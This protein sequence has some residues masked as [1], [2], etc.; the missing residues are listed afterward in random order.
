MKSARALVWG[1]V[2][3]ETI[4]DEDGRL[5][6]QTA[7]SEDIETLVEQATTFIMQYM[8]RFEME[9]DEIRHVL[10]QDEF[11]LGYVQGACAAVAGPASDTGLTGFTTRVCGELLGGGMNNKIAVFERLRALAEDD[12]FLK[13]FTTAVEDWKQASQTP[14]Q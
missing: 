9:D 5:V 2:R 14:A 8:Q 7:E 3:S 4:A 12:D 6:L 11:L 10:L 1:A 13:G